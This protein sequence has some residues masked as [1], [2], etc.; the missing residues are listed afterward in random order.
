MLGLVFAY[1]QMKSQRTIGKFQDGD[2]FD[3]CGS[4][5]TTIPAGTFSLARADGHKPDHLY[6]AL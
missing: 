3:M 6:M 1:L 4:L 5:G 2:S